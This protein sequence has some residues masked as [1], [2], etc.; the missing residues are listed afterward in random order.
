MKR[1]L[2]ALSASVLT[3]ACF[4]AVSSVSADAQSVYSVIGSNSGGAHLRS[5]PS[6]AGYSI[7]YFGNGQRLWMICWVDGQ[8]VSPPSADYTSSRW[9]LVDSVDPNGFRGYIHS[10][11]VDN[12]RS[13]PHC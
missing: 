4:T 10:S 8:T 13:A 12:Q 2:A 7:A 3:T 9:F 6:T 1:L 11:L 5:A